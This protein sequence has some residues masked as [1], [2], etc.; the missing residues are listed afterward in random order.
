MIEFMRI[1]FSE[2]VREEHSVAVWIIVVL[3]IVLILVAGWSIKTL[4]RIGKMELKELTNEIKGLT[5]QMATAE[6]TQR[7]DKKAIYQDMKQIYEG[8]RQ[9]QQ[10]Q[11]Q[12]AKDIQKKQSEDSREIFNLI[13]Q[14]IEGVGDKFD[15]IIGEIH[16][17]DI[18]ITTLEIKNGGNNRN[19]NGN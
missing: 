16:K 15:E 1:F 8:M 6:K 4:K 14:S 11:S 17:H 9:I 7:E 2:F 13:N 3:I 10:K 19:N 18:R 12:D 5:N